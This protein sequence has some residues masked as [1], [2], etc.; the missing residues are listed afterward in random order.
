MQ[1]VDL[2]YNSVNYNYVQSNY[3]FVCSYE[4]EGKIEE[5]SELLLVITRDIGFSIQPCYS[6]H[7][8]FSS[9]LCNLFSVADDQIS[10][11][12]F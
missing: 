5:D 10:N 3:F 7:S 6:F 12:S 2:F 8:I 4:W 1:L 9:S 11:S